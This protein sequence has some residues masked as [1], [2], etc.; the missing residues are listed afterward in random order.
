[1]RV[2]MIFLR[3]NVY[4][5]MELKLLLSMMEKHLPIPMAPRHHVLLIH[6]T[7]MQLTSSVQNVQLINLI[8]TRPPR[9]ARSV[10]K[11]LN[12]TTLLSNVQELVTTVKL[13]KSG[14][15]VKRNV[16][17]T[18]NVKRMKYSTRKQV[19]VK[20][21][22][23]RVKL[24]FALLLLQIGTVTL[25]HVKNVLW[26]PLCITNRQVNAQLVPL[27]QPMM[28]KTT[29]AS[30]TSHALLVHHSTQKLTAARKY[31]VLKISLK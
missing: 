7:G 27:I 8:S 25:S 14:M 6:L 20:S 17:L 3:R 31:N 26:L 5:S 1:M 13:M 30:P 21:N 15:K 16:Y 23:K 24:V 22:K 18:I 29:S 19:N 4:L 9:S 2:S 28:P 10:L 12:G 11:I